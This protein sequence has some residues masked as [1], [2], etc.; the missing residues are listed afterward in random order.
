MDYIDTVQLGFFSLCCLTLKQ[1]RTSKYTNQW[2]CSSNVEPSEL[3]P[4]PI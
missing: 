4:K 3:K 1:N 2:N